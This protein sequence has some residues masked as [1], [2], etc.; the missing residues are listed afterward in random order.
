[1]KTCIALMDKVDPPGPVPSLPRCAALSGIAFDDF[2]EAGGASSDMQIA[3]GT[4]AAVLNA[5]AREQFRAEGKT[6]AEGDVIIGLEK[7]RITAEAQADP[8]TI[9]SHGDELDRCTTIAR[10]DI[11]KD[12]HSKGQGG[13]PHP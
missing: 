9:E 4:L 10:P 13:S 7:E 8:A 11:A 5:Q 3:L 2:K 6:V 1:V 12:P